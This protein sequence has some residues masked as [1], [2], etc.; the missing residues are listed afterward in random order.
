MRFSDITA[1]DWA[2][3]DALADDYESIEQ[4]ESLVA[5][6]F[7]ASP[8]RL[9]ILNR[10]E[11]LHHRN[12]TFLILNQIFDRQ[13]LIEEIEEKTKNRP[14]WL[15]RTENGYLAWKELADKF[16]ENTERG[17]A[18]NAHPRHAGMLARSA[19][20]IRRATGERG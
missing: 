6:Y 11:Y 5:E 2:I 15:G 17:G 7:T 19:R 16:N 20:G 3:L 1:L 10:L 4:I 8:T 18:P 14:Y 12:Y 9:E 13:K